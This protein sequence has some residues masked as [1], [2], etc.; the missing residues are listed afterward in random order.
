D[1][2]LAALERDPDS[3]PLEP[4]QRAL[5][6][7]ALKLT[8][9][10]HSVMEDDIAALRAAGLFDAAIHDAAAVVAYFN[11]VNRMASGLNVELEE[12]YQR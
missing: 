10:P 6:D 2:L 11:F 4:R 12:T 5:V 1:E 3:A 9:A 8:R 7:Y